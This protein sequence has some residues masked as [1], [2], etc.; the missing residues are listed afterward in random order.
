MSRRAARLCDQDRP[1]MR[2]AIDGA[3]R[4]SSRAIS[5][6]ICAAFHASTSV[7]SR[8]LSPRTSDA[9]AWLAPRVQRRLTLARSRAGEQPFDREIFVQIRPV[10]PDPRAK[11][12]PSSSLTRRAFRKSRVPRERD[13]D[14]TAV[15]QLHNQRPISDANGL[16]R[17]FRRRRNARSIHAMLSRA[18]ARVF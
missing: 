7:A 5:R 15:A 13:G 1:R 16:G 11:Q 12:F 18:R 4:S 9:F 14:H 8:D 10:N 6:V 17:G 2:R 3:T